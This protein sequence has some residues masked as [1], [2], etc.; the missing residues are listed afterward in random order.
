MI[1]VFG[2]EVFVFGISFFPKHR[3]RLLLSILLVAMLSGNVLV[4]LLAFAVLTSAHA[5]L[6]TVT[7]KSRIRRLSGVVYIFAMST[8][9]VKALGYN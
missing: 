6:E 5:L 9:F 1:W 8:L 7:E 4:F 2:I 3:L